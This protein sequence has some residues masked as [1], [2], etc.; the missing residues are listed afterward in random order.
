MKDNN[1]EIK[2]TIPEF[3]KILTNEYKFE[4]DKKRSFENRA[5]ILITFLGGMFVLLKEEI[6]INYIFSLP[7]NFS[8][9]I[10]VRIGI[11]IHIFFILVMF[12]AIKIIRTKGHKNLDTEKLGQLINDNSYIESLS[13]VISSYQTIITDH[14]ELNEGRAENFKNAINILFITFIFII[15]Y[16][17]I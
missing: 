1:T 17:N 7:V 12:M 2:N 9:F 5:S 13:K 15:I 14:R 4:R 10:K 3:L 11:S 6:R 8:N 16:I